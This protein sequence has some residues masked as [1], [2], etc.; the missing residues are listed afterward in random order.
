MIHEKSLVFNTMLFMF[1]EEKV[2]AATQKWSLMSGG[3]TKKQQKYR[4]TS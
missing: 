2:L 4:K 1:N 3:L